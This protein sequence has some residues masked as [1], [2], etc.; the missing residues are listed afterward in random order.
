MTEIFKNKDF[1]GLK[2]FPIAV[3]IQDPQFACP[4][5]QHQFCEIAIVLGGTATHIVDGK[6]YSISESDV[7][8]IM[9]NTIH[10]FENREHLV[11]ANILFD[12]SELKI[13]DDAKTLPGYKNMF[14]ANQKQNKEFHSRL[15]LTKDAFETLRRYLYE[16]RDE[17]NHH[18]EGF[19]VMAKTIFTKIVI[20][21][22]R[23]YS[24]PAMRLSGPLH[25]ITEVMNYIEQN[26][27]EHI[28]LDDLIK[29]SHT[30]RRNLCRLFHEAMD[31][32]PIGYLVKI[33]I[34]HASELLKNGRS[35]ITE[36]AYKVGFQDGNYFSRQFKKIT[37]MTPKQYRDQAQQHFDETIILKE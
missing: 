15:K 33:R 18:Q 24:Q 9:G 21:L 25:R 28:D 20:F 32:S 16:L 19:E 31:E 37:G 13:D 27:K 11:L 5:H 34:N 7:F 26:Y 22:A 35:S 6:Y 2:Q 12:S 8:V 23:C 17:L 36:I 10:S 29:I 30:S 14:E 3:V 4:P 1:L